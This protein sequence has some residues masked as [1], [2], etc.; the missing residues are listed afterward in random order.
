[1]NLKLKIRC[2]QDIDI[3]YLLYNIYTHKIGQIRSMERFEFFEKITKMVF[4]SKDMG[5]FQPLQPTDLSY[6][7]A[8]RMYQ[9][10][11]LALVIHPSFQSQSW[12]E[13]NP[14]FP[15]I[16]W[17]LEANSSTKDNKL[18]GNKQKSPMFLFGVPVFYRPPREE[19]LADPSLGAAWWLAIPPP[20]G[21]WISWRIGRW[22]SRL[23]AG[24]PFPTTWDGGAKTL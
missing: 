4:T 18:Q 21:S 15:L 17:F 1:M 23:V 20:K 19:Q 11:L 10:W 9:D 12:L 16:P 14:S 24:I 5:D 2:I 6:G 8:P 22:R 3:I 13:R 7:L